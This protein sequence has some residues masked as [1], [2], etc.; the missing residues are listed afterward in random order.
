MKKKYVKGPDDSSSGLLMRSQKLLV[1]LLFVFFGVSN[2]RG[3]VT[4]SGA[5]SGNGPYSTLGEA[6]TAIGISQ[7]GANINIA[8]TG[9]TTELVTA[10]LGAGDWSSVTITPSG[11]SWTISGNLAS[12]LIQ[13]NGADNVTINGLNAGGNGLTIINTNATNTAGVAT[14]KFMAD[15]TNNTI[16]NCTV[17]GS[18]IAPTGVAAANL[19][20]VVYFAAGTAAGTGN[21]GNTIS[22]CNIGPAGTALPSKLIYSN[23]TTT[24]ETA[25]NSGITIRNCNLYDYFLSTGCAAVY[26][27]QGNSDWIINDNKIYQSGVR[28]FSAAGVMYGIYFSNATFG[29]NLQVTSNTIG[30]T[31]SAGTGFVN[32]SG[33]SFAGQ[34][35]GIYFTGLAGG[36][37]T[38]DVNNNTVANISLN[39]STGSFYGIYNGVGS[40][41]SSIVNINGNTIRNITGAGNTG[42]VNPIFGGAAATLNC[43]T[44]TIATISRSGAGIFYG[45][46][47]GIA[48]NVTVNGNSITNLSSTATGATS[49]A[50][51]GGIYCSVASLTETITNNTINGLASSSTSSQVVFGINTGTGNQNKTIQN[52]IVSNITMAAAST[53]TVHGIRMTN[54]GALNVISGNTI[55]SI[56]GPNKGAGNGINGFSMSSG[57]VNNVYNNKVYGLN[58]PGAASGVIGFAITGG[59]TYNIYNNIMGDLTAPTANDTH[60]VIGFNSWSPTMNIYNNTVVLNGSNSGTNFGS[61]I[62]YS[63]GPYTLRNNIMINN[64]PSRGSGVSV[65]LRLPGGMANYGATSDNNLFAGTN[66][67]TTS[68][69]TGLDATLAAF[70]TR[71]TGRDVSSVTET[72]T[73]VSTVGSDPNYLHINTTVPTQIESGGAAIPSVVTNDFDG[74][75]RSLTTPDIGADEFTGVANDLTAP[76]IVHTPDPVCAP[77]SRTIS[78]TFTDASGV[79]T[80]GTGMPVAYWRINSG[81]YTAVVGTSMGNG[82]YEFTIGTGSVMGDGVSYYFVAQ[83]NAAT[84]NVTVYPS[85]GAAG[86]SVNPPLA[87]T[88]PTTPLTLATPMNGIYT[89]GVGGNFTTLTAAVSDYNKRCLNGPVTFTLTDTAYASETYPIVI[90]QNA[91]ASAVKTLTIK[92]A[93]GVAAT[94]SGNLAS[95]LIQFNGADYVTIDGL[96]TG[97]SSLIISN[98]STSATAGTST[99]KFQADATN[100]TITNCTVLGSATVPNLTDG[101]VVYFATGTTTGNDGNTISNCNIGPAGS[102]LPSKLIYGKGTTTSAAI[103]N[104]GITITNCNLYDYFLSTGCAAVYVLAGNMDWT[105]TNNR[106]YQTGTRTFTAVGIMYGIHYSDPTNGGNVQFTGNTMGY[107]SSTGTG[108]LTLAES[109]S[110]A[111]HFQGIYFGAPTN[112]IPANNLNNNVISNISLT[113]TTGIFYGIYNGVTSASGNTTNI[114]GNTIRNIATTT[115]T[116]NVWAIFGGA[117]TTLNCS[118]NTIDNISRNGAGTLYGINYGAAPNVTV[119]GNIITNLSSTHATSTNNLAGIFTSA[120]S[121]NET[122]TNNVIGNLSSTSTAVMAVNGIYSTVASTGN[123]TFRKN[124]IS[125]LSLAPTGTGQLYG[126]RLTLSGPL[127]DISE[128]TIHT[129]TGGSTINGIQIGGGAVNNVFRNKIYGLGTSTA[130]TAVYGIGLSGGTTHNMYNNIIGDLTAS[131]ANLAGTPNQVV[132]INATN[133][134]ATL[135]LYHNTV[136]INASSTG[137]NFGS[138]AVSAGSTVALSMRNNI[139]V[140]TSAANGTGLSVVLRKPGLNTYDNASNNNLFYGTAI[141]TDNAGLTDLTLNEFKGRAVGR[142]VVS[143]TENP[144]FVSQVG[145][146]SGYLHIDAAIAT[147]VADAGTNIAMVTTD[148]DGEPRN[149]S[150]PDIGA[151]EFALVQCAAA[152]GGNST[153]A[154]ATIC[155]SGGTIISVNGHTVGNGITYQWES[156]SDPAFTTPVNEGVAATTYANLTTPTITA[157]TYYRLKVTCGAGMSGYSTVS[158][159]TVTPT[160][161]TDFTQ[162]AP[163]CSGETLAALPLTSNNGIAGTWSPALNN[164]ATTTYTFTPNSGQC[165]STATMTITVNP[166]TA[167]AFTQVAAICSGSTLSALPL[168]SNNGIAGTWSP[169][170][171]NAA[172]TTYTFT[173]SLGQCASTATMTITVNTTPAPVGSSTQT[174]SGGVPSDATIEDLTPTGPGIVWYPTAADAL[175][176]TNAIPAGTQ[177]TNGSVYYAMQ[178]VGGCRS[179]SYL[180]VTAS[181]TLGVNDFILSNLKLYPNPVADILKVENGQTISIIEVYSITGQRVMTKTVNTMSASIDMSPLA[182]G[183]Y[184]VKVVADDV[185]KTVKVIKK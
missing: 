156:S 176:G 140:N 16:T 15:A 38:Y 181:V 26:A 129:F 120:A 162:V 62:V 61:S 180:A 11:G 85:L 86:F 124:V 107:A 51:F 39:S 184:L 163:I 5:T 105:V 101:G 57:T 179:T 7:T 49:T 164:A 119:D 154:T 146:N 74:N 92:P 153:P 131:A 45:I 52:N 122:I 158:T 148:F 42:V 133:S 6:F 25:G 47:Y 34:F 50:I 65:V 35:Q 98:I 41:S 21:D 178:T 30:Y 72:P 27:G 12:E 91:D 75:T 59:T 151:D 167:P 143:V 128:N 36:T 23:G 139:L 100:N 106:M 87:A 136:K 115:T 147:Q 90:R 171:N 118:N 111:C 89:V 48:T 56:A 1:L 96:N 102:N 113:S 55:S 20:G 157:T 31:S 150:T 71:A 78:A 60:A 145:S 70:K 130:S 132:G 126:I 19:G 37:K 95:E 40:P 76:A 173:P 168:T 8:I 161:A 88:P 9:N 99:I 69:F 81:A 159:V 125:N 68:G 43:N 103:G 116:G 141:Y 83:D 10:S 104:S 22:Y 149:A 144:N 109:G 94:V 46:N 108:T 114:N 4:V 79:A 152:L 2:V 169:A 18:G 80:T 73:F 77:G 142:D 123:R 67:H 44:N 137:A 54:A 3:Q 63:D 183:T 185:V 166:A 165:A 13:L 110:G 112:S 182:G 135:N 17:L 93:S 97:G 174:I 175:A 160:V 117:A 32:L 33:S 58:G 28:S 127:T 172:T 82:V 138:S 134:V 121:A 177:L 66:I 170:L 29:S 64:L 84:P 155:T 53:G 24:P 14:I